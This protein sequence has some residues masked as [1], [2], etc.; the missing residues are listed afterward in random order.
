MIVSG[1]NN[2]VSLG[3]LKLRTINGD[4]KLCRYPIDGIKQLRYDSHIWNDIIIRADDNPLADIHGD[5]FEIIVEWILVNLQDLNLL[6]EVREF[7]LMPRIIYLRYK[8]KK[9]I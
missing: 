4:M 5:V 9:L 3:E 6:L 1:V 8:A 7:Y 2:N